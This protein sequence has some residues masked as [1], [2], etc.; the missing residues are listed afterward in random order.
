M[1]L[2][3]VPNDAQRAFQESPGHPSTAGGK[4]IAI[5][6][7]F[8]RSWPIA[9]TRGGRLIDRHSEG[10]SPASPAVQG[11][12]KEL[13]LSTKELENV[14]HLGVHQFSLGA[15]RHAIVCS[16]FEASF[17]SPRITAALVNDPTID[18]YDLEIGDCPSIDS[19]C[20]SALLPLSRNCSFELNS[21]SFAGVQG[22]AKSLGNRELCESLLDFEQVRLLR[23]R[24]QHLLES[25]R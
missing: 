4:T 19:N 24:S 14:A 17:L 25:L 16:C 2:S 20:V 23:C 7:D 9:G 12:R 3:S 13:R 22:L 1:G 21:S 15:R 5:R 18:K 11:R 10:V 8:L 6:Y